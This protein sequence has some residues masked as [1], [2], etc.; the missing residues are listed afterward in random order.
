MVCVWNSLLPTS[1]SVQSGQLVKQMDRWT[2]RQTGEEPSPSEG[3]ALEEGAVCTVVRGPLGAALS[4][5]PD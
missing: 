1:H 4:S 5:P 2:D 3:T